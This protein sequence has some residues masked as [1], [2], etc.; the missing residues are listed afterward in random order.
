MYGYLDESGAPG[1]V[2]NSAENYR[3]IAKKQ[4]VFLEIR[5]D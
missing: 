2:A 1:V 5:A 4:L 3:A